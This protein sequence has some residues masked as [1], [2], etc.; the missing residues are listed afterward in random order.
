MRRERGKVIMRYRGNCGA[1]IELSTDGKDA[2]CAKSNIGVHSN[3]P[4]FGDRDCVCRYCLD[5]HKSGISME[6]LISENERLV[7]ENDILKEKIEM[8]G[9]IAD[10]H[11]K[12]I[13]DIIS[14]K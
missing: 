8:L 4:M 13:R 2:V 6:D 1:V 12:T 3:K 10:I 5:P 11:S 14:A 7:K 9:E